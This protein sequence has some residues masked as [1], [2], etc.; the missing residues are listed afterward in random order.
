MH[1]N[2]LAFL[3]LKPWGVSGIW[4]L[5]WKSF[6]CQTNPFPCT[7]LCNLFLLRLMA[8]C[9]VAG[10]GLHCQPPPH[11]APLTSSG[12]SLSSVAINLLIVSLYLS[13]ILPGQ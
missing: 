9:E 5:T 1:S 4:L 6:S 7:F 3:R 12:V 13:V 10:Y 2:H 8:G 11:T